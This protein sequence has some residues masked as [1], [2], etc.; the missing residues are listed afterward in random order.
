MSARSHELS[1]MR[2]ISVIHELEQRSS[3]LPGFL[4]VFHDSFKLRSSCDQIWQSVSHWGDLIELAKC[5]HMILIQDG[6]LV[7]V[8]RNVCPFGVVS[9][10]AIWWS[11]RK[12]AFSLTQCPWMSISATVWSYQTLRPNNATLPYL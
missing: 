5:Y 11:A 9:I 6:C 7:F 10:A 12:D 3:Q 4:A 8:S 1:K 2:A